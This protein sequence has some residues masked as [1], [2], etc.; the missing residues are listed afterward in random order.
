MLRAAP[1]EQLPSSV[2]D[3]SSPDHS[4]DGLGSFKFVGAN[5]LE[6]LGLYMKKDDVEED[7]GEPQPPS[8]PN[9]VNDVEEGEID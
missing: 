7:E 6:Q 3:E 1:D 4:Q 2:N 5:P 9:P 8:V